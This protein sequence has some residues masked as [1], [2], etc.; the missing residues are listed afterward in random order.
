MRREAP[1]TLG[2]ILL[3]LWLITFGVIWLFRLTTPLGSLFLAVFAI[4]AGVFLFLG[5]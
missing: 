5:S 4:A 2:T 3:S 1:L